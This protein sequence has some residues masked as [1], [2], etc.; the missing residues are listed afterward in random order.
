VY[1]YAPKYP[2]LSPYHFSHNS[3]VFTKEIEGLE[4]DTK[5][6]MQIDMNTAIKMA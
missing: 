2:Y 5:F 6:N 4:G 3:P 1:P